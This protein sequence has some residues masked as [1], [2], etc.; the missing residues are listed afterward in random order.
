MACLRWSSTPSLTWLRH[1]TVP[2][3]WNQ[4]RLPLLSLPSLYLHAS[5]LECAFRDNVGYPC[6]ITL[7]AWFARQAAAVY[8][9]VTYQL[10]KEAMIWFAHPL[11]LS[12]T[13]THLVCVTRSTVTPL[14]TMQRAQI[15]NL[16]FVWRHLLLFDAM[17]HCFASTAC[18]SGGCSLEHAE[19]V[20][21]KLLRSPQAHAVFGVAKMIPGQ[22]TDKVPPSC[23]TCDHS[24][25]LM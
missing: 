6:C 15:N 20:F 3:V 24:R 13:V 7:Q 16:L 1:A 23:L 10:V 9:A 12:V 8:A 21:L 2:S 4:V 25:S 18:V 22:H 5:A 14:T 11:E 19:Y 17:V